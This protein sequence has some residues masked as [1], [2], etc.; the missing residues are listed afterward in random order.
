MKQILRT[1]S[2]P[3]IGTTDTSLIGTNPK[4]TGVLIVAPSSN[5]ISISL[6]GPA[7][8]DQG[9]TIYPS[10][11]PMHLRHEDFGDSLCNEIRAIS[12]LAAQNVTI[13]DLMTK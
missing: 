10:N 4:R 9:L 3:L 12:A 7:V 11:L 1:Q 5:R 2:S 6:T 8:L 13:I